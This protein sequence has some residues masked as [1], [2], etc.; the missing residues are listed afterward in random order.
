M[1]LGEQ[2]EYLASF[3]FVFYLFVY[4]LL[5]PFESCNFAK[6]QDVESQEE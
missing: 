4:R 5:K 1:E 3:C 6:I 2:V